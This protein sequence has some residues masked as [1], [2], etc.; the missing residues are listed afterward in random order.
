MPDDDYQ[1]PERTLVSGET[2]GRRA[3]ALKIGDIVGGNYK[4]KSVI[5]RGGM[6]V[7]YC[8]SHPAIDRD[9]ALKA[10]A[11]E[12]IDE[13]RW[14]RFQTEGRAIARLDHPN[15]VKVYDLG[16]DGPDCLYYV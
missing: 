2:T 7:V 10:L 11:P 6:G 5:G 9:V 14:E 15:I 4:I 3:R 1:D 12:Q 8:A 13:V 16:A